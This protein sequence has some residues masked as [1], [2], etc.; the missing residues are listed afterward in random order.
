[1][2]GL[3]STP[4]IGANAM[5]YELSE[6][7]HAI[8][9]GGIGMM[10]KLAR[11]TGLVSEIDR[12]VHLL[13]VHAPYQETEHLDRWNEQGVKFNFG[14]ENRANLKALAEDLPESA[15]KPLTR[16]Q[17]TIKTTERTKPLN[18]KRQIIRERG[19]VHLELEHEDVAEFEYK[20]TAC[21]RGY[22][23][24]VV[25]KNIS[26]EQ[27]EAVLFDEI[28][29]FFYI[30]NDARSVKPEQVVFSC[31]K[32]CDQENL[33]AQLKSGVRSL[34]APTDNLQI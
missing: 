17:R 2:R 25:R 29:Y 31:N 19:Y 28:R 5:Q 24:I 23:M 30:S 10:L 3:D 9:H 27:G 7:V 1:M 15:W 32:R 20:P 33:I 22:R 16:S 14:Y 8:G 11:Q 34:C 13:K 26:K 18:V 12:R 4:V 21:H 6:R